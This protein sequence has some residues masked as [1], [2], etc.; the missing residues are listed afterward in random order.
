MNTWES[1]M[2]IS[3]FLGFGAA[4]L[5]LGCATTVVPPPPAARPTCE[6]YEPYSS[7]IARLTVE[8]IGTLDPRYFAVENG[9]LRRRFSQCTQP[10]I[11]VK[12]IDSLL[13]I[14][15][16]PEA[17]RCLTRRFTAAVRTFAKSKIEVC[18]TWK[19]ARIIGEPTPERIDAYVRRLPQPNEKG[20]LPADALFPEPYKTFF[21]YD[22]SFPVGTL[23]QPC[24][25]AATCAAECSQGFAGF[26]MQT[27]GSQVL[28]DDLSWL[29][30]TAY[31]PGGNPYLRRGFYHPMATYGR[32]PGHQFGDWSRGGN[33]E[34]CSRWLSSTGVL[35]TNA[36]V[37]TLPGCT[38]P[39][40]CQ[41]EC[42]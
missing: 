37:T 16:D 9:F 34:L 31:A 10:G 19:R 2:Q 40:S 13:G 21:L 27:D 4:V 38:G 25:E 23:A 6:R 35:T 28:V 15:Q 24:R 18:P 8:C 39:F 30:P 36:R 22:V 14:Q 41:S 5:G 12:Q 17:K 3:P 26:V 33:G 20:E 11:E 29:D 42:R 7:M 32:Y 1:T